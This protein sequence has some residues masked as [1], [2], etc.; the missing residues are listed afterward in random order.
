MII[1]TGRK[2]KKNRK[3]YQLARRW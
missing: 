2:R 3:G 1:V